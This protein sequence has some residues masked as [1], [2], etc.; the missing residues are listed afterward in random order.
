MNSAQKVN[1]FPR[2]YTIPALFSETAFKRDAVDSKIG[3]HGI[4]IYTFS[5]VWVWSRQAP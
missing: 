5:S 4:L 1:R 2:S 3:T